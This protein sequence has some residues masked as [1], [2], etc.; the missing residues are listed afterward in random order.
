MSDTRAD[1]V[2]VGAGAYGLSCAWWM[3][4]RDSN[5]KVLV[6][7][8]GEFASG[9]TGR[10]GAGMRMQ[11]GLEF[12]IRLAQESITFFE[13][14]E[15]RLDYP[16]GIE[17][18]QHGYLLLAHSDS[19]LD[20]FAANLKLQHDLGV[21][22]EILSPEDCLNL[23]PSLNPEGIAGGAI[24]LRDGTASPFLWLDALLRAARREGAEVRFGTPVQQIERRGD[25]FLVSTPTETMHVGK[26]L[27]CTDWAA[28]ELLKPLGVDLPISGMPKEALVTEAWEPLLGPAIVSFKHDMFVNQMTRGSIVAIPT[29]LRPDGDDHDSTDDFLPFAAEQILDLLPALAGVN[30]IRSWA[31]V[32]SKTPDMQA[33]IGETGVPNLYVAVSAYKG[34]MTSPA[35]GRV[36]AEIVIDGHSNHPAVAPLSARRF[37]TGEL[38]PEP[39]TV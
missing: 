15:Q 7:D 34:F 17:L 2:I 26:V 35:V 37:E 19:M 23:V 20:G 10:N 39:L 24:C 32:I 28:P 13:D 9:G 30:V 22:S 3:A 18:K 21:P 5:P 6:L 31:G 8:A 1:I 33:V 29:R 38:V 11:W 36:M 14:A 16:G 12:N 25:N 4:Q 27:I